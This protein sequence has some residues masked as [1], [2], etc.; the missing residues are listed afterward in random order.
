M[1]CL[2]ISPRFRQ[3][4]RWEEVGASG[5]AWNWDKSHETHVFCPQP[6]QRLNSGEATKE[7]MLPFPFQWRRVSISLDL[8]LKFR[9]SDTD[10]LTFRFHFWGVVFL[11]FF[12]F[13]QFI[14]SVNFQYLY[15]LCHL[16]LC[17][18]VRGKLGCWKITAVFI[19][20][21]NTRIASDTSHTR[22]PRFPHS[23]LLPGDHVP[24]CALGSSGENIQSPVGWK[25]ENVIFT[26]CIF[27]IA[28]Y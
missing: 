13:W 5:D 16:T 10:S 23:A 27:L 6:A 2:S 12:F 7:V 19:C 24:F 15:H 21:M 17:A 9:S 26:V 14:F 11:L 4:H 3:E 8:S 22:P 20:M 28:S 25:V 1:G 18:P